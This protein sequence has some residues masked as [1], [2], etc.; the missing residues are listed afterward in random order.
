MKHTKEKG[1]FFFLMKKA[2]ECCMTTSTRV[3]KG[4][5]QNDIL[6]NNGQ[7]FF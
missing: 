7:I 2:S 3:F 5:E 6:T 1:I 4:E